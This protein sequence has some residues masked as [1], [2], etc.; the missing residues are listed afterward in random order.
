MLVARCS[1]AQSFRGSEVSESGDEDAAARE[2]QIVSDALPRGQPFL[3]AERI[4]P[5]V[6]HLVGQE[7]RRLCVRRAVCLLAAACACAAGARVRTRHLRLQPAQVA[8]QAVVL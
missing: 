2:V 1:K 4:P 6:V 7:A 5:L 8:P 3:L